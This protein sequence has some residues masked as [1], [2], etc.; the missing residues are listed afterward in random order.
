MSRLHHLNLSLVAVAVFGALLAPQTGLNLVT[1]RLPWLGHGVGW[2]ESLAPGL[3][4]DHLVAFALLAFSSRIALRRVPAWQ[5]LAGLVLSAG[6]TELAQ[7]WVPGR[8]ASVIDAG[9]DLAGALLGYTVALTFCKEGR[10]ALLS[11]LP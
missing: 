9:L 2:L 11:R 1:T 3:D 5:V 4:L 7:L 8:T 10:R 6:L